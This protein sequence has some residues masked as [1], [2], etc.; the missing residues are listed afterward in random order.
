MKRN[1]VHLRASSGNVTRR[2]EARA[3]ISAAWLAG[4]STLLAIPAFAAD[5]ETDA[6]IKAL[7]EQVQA[8][9]T[10][11]QDLKAGTASKYVETQRQITAVA[12]TLTNGRPTI[13]ESDGAFSA[14]LRTLVQFDTGNY[15]QDNRPPPAP[16]LSS[17]SD[18]RRSR[19]GIEGKVFTDWEYNFLYDFGGSGVE[20]STITSAYIQYNALPVQLRIGAFAP[21]ANFEDSAGA[22]DLLFLERATVTEIQRSLA[23]GDG[24]SAFSVVKAGERAF[25]SLALTG[26]RANQSGVLDEQ[27]ALLGRASYLIESSPDS[28]IA[29]GANG[30]WIYKTANIFPPPGVALSLG[31]PPELRVDDTGTNGAPTN[32]ITT[33]NLNANSLKQWGVDGGGNYKSLYLEGGYYGFSV[34]RRNSLPDADFYGWYVA[35]SWMLTGEQRRYDPTRGAFRSPAVLH[36]VGSPGWQGAT[37]AGPVQTGWGAWELAVRYS[38]MDLTD[39]EFDPVAANRI[40]GGEQDIWTVGLNWYIN[41][42][43]KAQLNYQ[44]VDVNRLTAAGARLG[45]DVDQ[46]SMRWQF[47]F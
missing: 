38:F 31:N 18:F 4:V 30:T 22:A 26:G 2:T 14:S 17:G 23:G 29:I 32:L 9:S 7:E 19:F 40:R 34:D 41:N 27:Q 43:I 33:G 1:I 35:A 5:P 11:I 15:D 36:P 25:G 28:K 37:P 21:Y 24:R 13:T 16:K 44:F 6:K 8:L 47:A 42:A 39:H 12:P 46:I 3:R 45:Q 20:G 10:Q